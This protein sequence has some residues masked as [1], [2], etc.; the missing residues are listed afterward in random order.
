[1]HP[2]SDRPKAL[3]SLFEL[4]G[5]LSTWTDAQVEAFD[6]SRPPESVLESFANFSRQRISSPH[7]GGLTG[8]DWLTE[9]I[10]GKRHPSDFRAALVAFSDLWI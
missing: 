8:K 2:I 5:S 9:T 6:L 7:I 4:L 10:Q 3:A 1:M